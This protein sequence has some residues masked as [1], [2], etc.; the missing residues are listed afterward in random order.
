MSERRYDVT[1][2]YTAAAR[3]L[4]GDDKQLVRVSI[5]FKVQS[6][7]NILGWKH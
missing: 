4:T 6:C 5:V 3:F 1:I 2:D 7:C